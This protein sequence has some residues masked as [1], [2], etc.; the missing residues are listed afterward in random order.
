MNIDK[1]KHDDGIYYDKDGCG[2]MTAEDFIQTGILGFCGCGNPEVS[3]DIVRRALKIIKNHWDNIKSE[4]DQNGEQCWS[5]YEFTQKLAFYSDEMWLFIMYYLD[6]KELTEHGG[7]VNG[8]WL[9]QKGYDLL[10]DL[11]ELLT[12]EA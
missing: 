4:P 10:E 3:L 1:Y 2:Y 6:S 8:A 12:T 7:S 9:T 11:D 5:E